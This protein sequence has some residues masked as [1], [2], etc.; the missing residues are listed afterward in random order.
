MSG[1]RLRLAVLLILGATAGCASTG[2]VF[3]PISGGSPAP[4]P[5]HCATRAG[6]SGTSTNAVPCPTSS[7]A[8][9]TLAIS[10]N[11]TAL[12]VTLNGAS[13]G[14]TPVNTT[15]TYA[16]STA[17]YAIVP[18]DGASPF[19]YAFQQ[20]NSANVALYYN[21]VADT[22]GSIGTV[23]QASSLQRRVSAATFAL[24]TVRHAFARIV[25]RPRYDTTRIAVFYRA[26]ALQS[27]GRTVNDIEQ[28]LGVS[29][30]AT[31]GP[32]RADKITRVMEIP[33]GQTYE[34]LAA[35]LAQ[36]PAVIGTE[37]IQ[38]RYTQSVTPLYPD[39]PHFND[40]DQW[41]MYRIN[42]P[43]AWGYTLG[44]SLINIAVIDTGADLTLPDLAGKV[45]YAEKVVDGVVTFGTGAVVDLDGHGTNVAGIADAATNN[46]FG[47]AGVGYNTSL[48]VYR[49]FPDP[50]PPEYA[51]DP[52]YGSNTADEA[53]AIYDAVARGANVINLSLGDPAV[54]TDDGDAA[55]FSIIEHDAVEYAISQGVTVVAAAGNGDPDTGVA[56]STVGYPGAYAGVIS[57]GASTLDDDD[58]GVYASS[59]NES[60][61]SYSDYGPTLAVVAPGGDPSGDCA[62]CFDLLHWITNLGSTEVNDPAGQC[63]DPGDCTSSYAGTSQATPHVAGAAA[64]MLAANPNLTPAQILQIIENTADDIGAGEQE[65]HGRID[66]YRALAAVEGDTAPSPPSNANFVAFAYIPNGTTK[67][68]IVD[69]TYTHGVQ[70]AADGTFRIA[71]IP[72][73][74]ANYRIGVWYDANGDGL[75]D[76]GD[77]FG[78]TSITCSATAPCTAAQGLVVQ[79]VSA[80]FVLN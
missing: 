36:D 76:Q 44:L 72:P 27:S 47:F 38:M 16:P 62:S 64:L 49:I 29:R 57:V 61:A 70:V 14:T 9:S 54:D 58:T 45:T 66:L 37:R 80:G 55:G 60:V 20:N 12:A 21:Q 30:V 6:A 32:V 71:D 17:T 40:T 48:Q 77:W 50:Q 25:G 15:P 51:S 7:P 39:D 33:P 75:V 46:G 63:P 1:T 52:N 34:S 41:D 43:Y 56:Y 69:V 78:A 67:P 42:A 79:P 11:P 73:S 5:G 28:P 10:S 8:L 74:A 22:W 24:K 13:L 68:D 53:Q 3:V 35:K 31:V 18:S 59:L 4:T 65:G 2:N 19:V 26:S 23:A